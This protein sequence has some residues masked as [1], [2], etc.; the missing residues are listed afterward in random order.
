MKLIAVVYTSTKSWKPSISK[1][2]MT[3]QGSPQKTSPLK[4]PNLPLF[5]PIPINTFQHLKFTAFCFPSAR[6][7]K[8][9]QFSRKLEKLH[10][11]A[12]V[13]PRATEKLLWT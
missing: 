1:T 5:P 11:P 12:E 6:E 8:Q 7:N 4:N 13:T 2:V 9:W 3:D 10:V